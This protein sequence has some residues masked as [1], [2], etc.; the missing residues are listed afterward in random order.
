MSQD[1]PGEGSGPRS[2]LD[3]T[4][5]HWWLRPRLLADRAAF[6]PVERVAHPVAVVEVGR[7]GAGSA[8]GP[9]EGSEQA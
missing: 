5:W 2:W 4:R 8:C 9:T 7:E 6:C 3:L 1:H